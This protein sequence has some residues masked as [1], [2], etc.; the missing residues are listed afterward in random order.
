MPTD[1]I[2]SDTQA[3]L[4][5]VGKNL[6]YQVLQP[7]PN[8]RMRVILVPNGMTMEDITAE[9]DAL[10]DGPQRLS[11]NVRLNTLSSFT[12][13]VNRTKTPDSA[14]YADIT[15]DPP[16]IVAVIDH[17]GPHPAA[18]NWKGATWA[19]YRGSMALKLSEPWKA[20]AKADG[21][22]V[23]QAAF[24]EFIEDRY[25]E[26]LYPPDTMDAE[27]LSALRS[28]GAKSFADPMEMRE[29]SK[30]LEVNEGRT[31][32][33]KINLSTGEQQLTF[34]SKL[35]GANGEDVSVLI[36]QAFLIALPVFEG[37][38]AFRVPVRLRVKAVN[39]SVLFAPFIHRPD[40]VLEAA[41]KDALAA[42]GE[43]CPGVQ[44][45]EG[46]YPDNHG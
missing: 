14:I 1:N 25:G 12:A 5:F 44:V 4:D 43:A 20:W 16:S 36:P 11:G 7:D 17:P 41:K 27:L 31:L 35:V 40:L 2:K 13:W 32:K 6:S 21:N 19:K 3:A 28:V 37:T 26:L 22:Y 45:F 10:K 29:V 24:A 39:Q 9:I 34:E 18:E 30:G 8:S 38:D 46:L 23:S 15:R 42:I 33:S